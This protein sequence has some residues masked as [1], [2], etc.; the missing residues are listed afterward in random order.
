MLRWIDRMLELTSKHFADFVQAR[1]DCSRLERVAI[2]LK[3]E[4]HQLES[5]TTHQLLFS[6]RQRWEWH[7]SSCS[8][9]R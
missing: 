9:I 1:F 4:L 2:I 6:S 3:N 8:L 5:A 7:V